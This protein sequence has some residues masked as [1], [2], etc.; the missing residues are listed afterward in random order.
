MCLQQNNLNVSG[1][2]RSLGCARLVRLQASGLRLSFELCHSDFGFPACPAPPLCRD[3]GQGRC[4]S[5]AG[6]GEGGRRPGEGRRVMV[7]Q[8]GAVSIQ[9]LRN[10]HYDIRTCPRMSLS[11][12]RTSKLAIRHSHGS[13]FDIVP[14]RWTPPPRMNMKSASFNL[15][16]SEAR[17]AS[18]FERAPQREKEPQPQPKQADQ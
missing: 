18:Q 1:V 8:C 16:S 10:S 12:L 17:R 14:P 3:R 13:S 5:L 7:T 2:S 4:P 9:H 15:R 11:G 6:A